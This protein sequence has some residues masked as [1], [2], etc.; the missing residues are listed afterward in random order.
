MLRCRADAVKRCYRQSFL[1]G[2][3]NSGT[4]IFRTEVQKRLVTW[5]PK[6]VS[7][8]PRS[9]LPSWMDQLLPVLRALR[10]PY[11]DAIARRIEKQQQQ[12]QQ[13][14]QQIQIQIYIYISGNWQ[15][16]L[17]TTSSYQYIERQ[18]T[19]V[20]REGCWMFTPWLGFRCWMHIPG[21]SSQKVGTYEPVVF[22]PV[23]H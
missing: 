9:P 12:Q 10:C 22:L 20:L 14:Q 3:A 5:Q 15:A 16:I 11:F 8:T 21:I 1:Q 17:A 13:Q 19:L 18:L 2:L 7:P 4:G 6:I 23:A